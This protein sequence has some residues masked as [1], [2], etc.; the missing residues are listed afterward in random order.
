MF[1]IILIKIRNQQRCEHRHTE[2][3]QKQAD[4]F[5]DYFSLH[6]DDTIRLDALKIGFN[7]FDQLFVEHKHDD[8]VVFLENRIMVNGNDFSAPD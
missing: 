4:A 7:V 2:Q 5:K 1:V 3:D 6:N 8:V